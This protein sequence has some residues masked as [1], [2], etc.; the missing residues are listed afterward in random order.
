[1]IDSEAPGPRRRRSRIIVLIVLVLGAGAALGAVL[2]PD[3]LKDREN[4]AVDACKTAIDQVAPTPDAKAWEESTIQVTGPD[5]DHLTVT[6]SFYTGSTSS[7][8]FTCVVTRKV[9]TQAHAGA[10]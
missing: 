10:S 2:W 7:Q 9:V 3:S 4:K 6:G 8:S 1:V 5:K